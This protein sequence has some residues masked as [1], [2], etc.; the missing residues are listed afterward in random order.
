MRALESY[1]APARTRPGWWRPIL[2]AFLVVAFWFV[3]VM[4]PFV[5][6]MTYAAMRGQDPGAFMAQLSSPDSGNAVVTLVFLATFAGFW[7]SLWIVTEVLHGQRFLTLFAPERSIRLRQFATGLGLAVVF[8]A[9]ALPFAL[10]LL[11]APVRAAA[12]DNWLL[13]L[14]P[15]L[16]CVFIQATAEE[17]VFRGYLLQQLAIRFRSPVIWGGLPA[18]TFGILHVSNVPDPQHAAYYVAIT[19]VTGMTFAALVWRTGAL[20]MAVGMHVGVNVLTLTVLGAEGIVSGTQIWLYPASAIDVLLPV[21][22]G[23][24]VLFFGLVVSPLGRV[25]G[26]G[27]GPFT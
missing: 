23:L 22:L 8:N 21:N 16:I 24:S 20:W 14:G 15:I 13:L 2:G 19:T 10:V 9:A 27:R 6:W 25:L 12:L 17:L 7:A 1:I 3:I 26:D 11:E 4:V 5:A 18:L